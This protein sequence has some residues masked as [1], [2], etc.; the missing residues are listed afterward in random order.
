MKI[1]IWPNPILKQASEPVLEPLDNDLIMQ[2][3]ALMRSSGGIGLSAIQVGNPKA[4][5]LFEDA[6]LVKVAVNPLIITYLGDST[7]MLE[8][9]LS[10]PGQFELVK[11]YPE[12][13]VVYWTH[14]LQEE[15]TC[16]PARKRPY[17]RPIVRGRLTIS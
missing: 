11:R 3:A 9:C 6:G 10:L 1:L 5:F 12:I 2:M 8:G 7:P 17:K 15:G 16:V 4:F 13:E 14:N